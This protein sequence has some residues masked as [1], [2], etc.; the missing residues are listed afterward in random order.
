MLCNSVEFE[1]L[2]T[3][4]GWREN[5]KK[6]RKILFE[7][8]HSNVIRANEFYT[9]SPTGEK[10]KTKM[11]THTKIGAV[12]SQDEL[13]TLWTAF[14]IYHFFFLGL[15]LIVRLVCFSIYLSFSP[16]LYL[17]LCCWSFVVSIKK[18][19]QKHTWRARVNARSEVT[20]KKRI[21]ET[22]SISWQRYN[23]FL[24]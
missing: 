24:T 7:S 10:T 20:H 17:R 12:Q 23:T 21:V 1:V 9:D 22:F 6:R 15:L 8:R 4:N 2:K 18:Y 3:N 5:V 11:N 13:Q 14:E 19:T 16:S